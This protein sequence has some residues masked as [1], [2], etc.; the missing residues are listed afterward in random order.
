MELL[1]VVVVVVGILAAT[2]HRQLQ[3]PAEAGA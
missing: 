3:R 2:A 1:M